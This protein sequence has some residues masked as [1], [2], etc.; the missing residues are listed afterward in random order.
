MT[1]AELKS[2]LL[3]QYPRENE[4]CE[5][6]AY[7]SPRYDIS[8]RKGEDVIS[9]VSAFANLEGGHLIIGIADRTGD[10][11]GIGNF[12]DY[13]PENLPPRLL[14]NCTNLSSEGLR[15]ESY[16]TEDSLKTVWVLHV[17]KHLPRRPVYAHKTAW[18]RSGDNL[19]LLRPERERAILS[20]PLLTIDDWS[21]EICP[22][23]TID[24]LSAEA[25]VRARNNFLKKFPH[26][27]EEAQF[28]DDITFLNKAKITVR[29]EI[30]RAALLLIGRPEST[31]F[32]FPAQAH[33]TWILKDKDNIE[34]DY[35]HF[36]PPFLLNAEEVFRRIRNLKYRYIRDETTLFPEEVDMY[37]PFVIREA[38]HNCIA[39]QDYTLAGRIIVVEFADRLVFVNSGRFIPGTIEA[40]IYSDAPETASRNPFLAHAMFNL[41][42]IDTIGSGIKRMFYAQRKRYFPMPDYIIEPEKVT[43]AVLGKIL[44]QEYVRLL[45]NNPDISLP[46]IILLD[47]VQK[48]QPISEEGAKL[49]KQKGYIEGRKPNFHISARVAVITGN[50][51]DYIRNRAFDD[52]HYKKM[53]TDFIAKFGSASRKDID[54]L[55][56]DKL[57]DVLNHKQKRSKVG[58]LLTS[59]RQEGIISNEGTSAKPKWI[60]IRDR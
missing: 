22:D 21:G 27:V 47:Q 40:A 59:L 49:L 4:S 16:Q 3:K 60:L 45:A 15:L 39:H 10:I 12:H 33:I 52:D 56:L 28:W 46:E 36:G 17:P 1:E 14:G 13:T 7:N 20:E 25:I 53:I 43:V 18:Q 8:G 19:I 11:I 31:H 6:K 58:N 48:K 23:A 44:D 37:D 29:G 50:K 38:L 30:T 55:I 54:Y 5:W 51:A 26:L 42:M 9:Y 24:D 35:A 32:L 41:N 57:S 2:Y 34:L